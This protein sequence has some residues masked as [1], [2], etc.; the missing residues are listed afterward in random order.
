MQDRFAGSC[1]RESCAAQLR[2]A[3]EG[4]IAPR[5]EFL[6]R[7]SPGKNGFEFFRASAG[8]GAKVKPPC[9]ANPQHFP[10]GNVRYPPTL[11]EFATGQR[12]RPRFSASHRVLHGKGKPF[13]YNRRLRIRRTWRLS[14]V[15]LRGCRDTA[16][17]IE[18]LRI[19]RT[20]RLSLVLLRGAPYKKILRIRQ[21]W[22]S[23][24]A[25]PIFGFPKV[26]SPGP[27]PSGGGC[28]PQGRPERE[29]VTEPRRRNDRSRGSMQTNFPSAGGRVLPLPSSASRGIGGRHLPPLGEGKGGK[30]A[31]AL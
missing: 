22:R 19:C 10:I 30:H 3:W 23:S 2:P 31:A 8:S 25:F 4:T 24:T 27:S 16:P 13:P 20:W 11:G 26:P 14:L 9:S 29:N 21:A 28:R 18:M 6:P 7:Q 15:L 5:E 12:I 1:I 17:Y